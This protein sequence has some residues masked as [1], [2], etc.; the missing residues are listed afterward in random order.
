MH[1]IAPTLGRMQCAPTAIA[2]TAVATG[3]FAQFAVGAVSTGFANTVAF[4]LSQVVHV[5]VIKPSR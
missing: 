1:G 3:M 2:Y 4:A 5:V